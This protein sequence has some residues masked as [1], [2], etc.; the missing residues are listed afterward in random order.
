MR[1]Q[2]REPILWLNLRAAMTVIEQS[3]GYVRG[4]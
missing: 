3:T 1:L 4:I 2:M